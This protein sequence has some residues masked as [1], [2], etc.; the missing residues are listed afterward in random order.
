MGV[1]KQIVA[2]Y[3]KLLYATPDKRESVRE[4]II[5]SEK[6][7]VTPA[8]AGGGHCIEAAGQAAL[9]LGL[10]ESFDPNLKPS[11]TIEYES[12]GVRIEIPEIQ[13]LGGE[14]VNNLIRGRTYR[15][16]YAVQFTESASNVRFG[17]LIKTISGVE[18]GGGASASSPGDSLSY[19]EAGSCYR[20][21]F[22]FQCALTPGVY[23]MN[24][25]VVGDVN[26][27]E[28]FLH[29]LVDAAIFRVQPEASNL[30]TGI[31]DFGCEPELELRRTGP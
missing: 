28:T 12:Q 21:Q 3:Q 15:Y 27:T 26:G 8:N 25:G 23:F 18:L 16:V 1:P 2:R 14:R 7:T 4:E 10:K 11:S 19:V 22:R 29:R 31:V 17:M 20:V 5:Q 9:I 30:A 24:A 13:T 6:S